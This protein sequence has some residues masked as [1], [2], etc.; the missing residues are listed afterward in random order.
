ML[1]VSCTNLQNPR[2]F[3]SIL[4]AVVIMD[5]KKNTGIIL[6]LLGLVLTMDRTMEFSGIVSAIS[7]YLQQYW[8]L[9]L[10]FVG[11]YLLSSPKKKK[12][13]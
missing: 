3:L 5:M 11:I 10:M 7:Y 12:K 8:P 13:K 9:L 4:I 1:G 6:I 2:L